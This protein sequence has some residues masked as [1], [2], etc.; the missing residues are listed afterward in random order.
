[1]W[2]T[3]NHLKDGLLV[4]EA[5]GFRYVTNVCWAKKSF[6]LG[7]YFRGQHELCLFGVRGVMASQATPRN[8]SSLITAEKTVH[9][10]KPVELYAMIERIS[11]APRL[12]MFAR[13][14]RDGWTSAGNEVDKYG[15]ESEDEASEDDTGDEEN[16]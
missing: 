8:I 12:E 14:T 1:M 13:N 15:D 11:P 16:E 5:L 9:S 4:M 7:Q 3:N 10:K 6:G 2:V